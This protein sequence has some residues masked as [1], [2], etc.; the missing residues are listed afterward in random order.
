MS[1]HEVWASLDNEMQEKFH[2]HWGEEAFREVFVIAGMFYAHKY[3]KRSFHV[4]L[5]KEIDT[6]WYGSLAPHHPFH[7]LRVL[8][9]HA[10]GDVAQYVDDH[11][12]SPLQRKFLVFD[13]RIVP[14]VEKCVNDFISEHFS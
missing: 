12:G 9:Q 8:T 14:A 4:D 3:I 7:R 10:I 5:H 11:F 2:G 1:I 6:A 13:T